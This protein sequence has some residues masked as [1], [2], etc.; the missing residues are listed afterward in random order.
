MAVVVTISAPERV[1]PGERFIVSGIV[2]ESTTGVP[3]PSVPVDIYRDSAPLGSATTGVDG[4]YLDEV[5]IGRPGTYQLR[6]RSMGVWSPI[7]TISIGIPT[8]MEAVVTI[9][10]PS[11]AVV[12]TIFTISGDVKE[13]G[14]PVVN[15]AV[16]LYESGRHFV[17]VMT[18]SLG[19]YSRSH[20]INA[21]GEYELAARYG[22]K[23]AR[24]DITIIEAAPPPPPPPPP[25]PKP[26][27]TLYEVRFACIPVVEGVMCILDGEVQYSNEIGIASFFNVTSGIHYYSVEKEGM[28]VVSGQ[29]PWR[30]PLVE[31]GTTIIEVPGVPEAEWPTDQPWLLSFTF[32][33]IIPVVPP[34]VLPI[35]A[36]RIWHVDYWYEGLDAWRDLETDFVPPKVGAEIH[37]GPRWVNDGNIALTGH[38]DMEITSPTGVKHT[39]YA[40]LNQDMKTDPRSGFGVQFEP[41]LID[42]AGEWG[43]R[44]VLKVEGSPSVIADE[45]D[46][47]FSVEEL[48]PDVLPPVVPPAEPPV[49]PPLLPPVA[50]PVI[51]P[52]IP[53]VIPVVPGIPPEVEHIIVRLNMLLW[54]FWDIKEEIRPIA[55]KA[56][57]YSI[58][59]VDLSTANLTFQTHYL[60]G[61]AI[62]ILKCTGF[63][64]L[65]IG[66][67]ATDSITIDPLIYPQTIVIDMMDFAKLY[68]RNA[69]Q[70][71]REVILIIWRR[72]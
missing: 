72:E 55:V 70:A 25:P 27:P 61:F 1:D 40:V 10:A 18:D 65:K 5:R 9:D 2:Y 26:L 66:D 15:R 71:G 42:E 47:T 31:S 35:V 41:L 43:V 64:E 48:P 28:R 29:D 49:L 17:T 45:K 21:L 67:L 63:L 34:E 36:G 52:A 7:H 46:Y 39:P 19:R 68:S 23:F 54:I 4:D 20:T 24:V 14:I 56:N 62:T 60:S 57:T 6:A 37:F 30:R 22:A 32:E 38:V 3:Y 13:D 69:A 11:T 59:T 12:S 33:E 51:P 50:V 16:W 53:P 44:V 8:P 58:L